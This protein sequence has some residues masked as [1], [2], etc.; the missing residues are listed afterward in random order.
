MTLEAYRKIVLGDA[1]M[2][3]PQPISPQ[4]LRSRLAAFKNEMSDASFQLGACACCAREKRRC[5]LQHV[6]FPSAASSTAPEWLRYTTEEWLDVREEWFQ[7]VDQ[8]LNVNNYLENVFEADNWPMESPTPSCL[9]DTC[10]HTCSQL[11]S[12]SSHGHA[13]NGI[14]LDLGKISKNISGR[15]KQILMS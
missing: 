4:I 5:K 7:Q 3:W 13:I 8:L 14:P 2:T 1:L 11:P 9:A 12:W 15:V 6:C 10:F